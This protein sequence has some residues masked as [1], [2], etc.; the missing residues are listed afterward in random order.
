[1]EKDINELNDAWKHA[2]DS[3]VM[4]AATQ[5]FEEYPPHVQAII[6]TEAKERGLWEKVLYL[7][8]EKTSEPK[9]G[10][11]EGYV[12][13]GCKGTYLNFETG[14]C[15]RCELPS[16]DMGYCIKCNK[17]WPIQPGQLCPEHDVKLSRHKAAMALLR[18]GNDIFDI[19]ILRILAFPAFFLVGIALS[20]FVDPNSFG[21]IDPLTE[22][23]LGLSYVFLYYFIFESI[24]QRT[25]GK[26]IT[27]TRVI[28]GTGTKPSMG[29][30]AKRTLIRFV[31]FEAFSFLGENVYG[32]HDRWSGTYVVKAK[33][34]ASEKSKAD[35]LSITTSS[36]EKEIIV[37]KNKKVTEHVCVPINHDCTEN[38]PSLAIPQEEIVIQEQNNITQTGV[39]SDKITVSSEK[40]KPDTDLGTHAIILSRLEECANCDRIIGKLE[41]AYIFK[42]HIV[43]KQCY[44]RLKCQ[45]KS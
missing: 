11:L 44:N 42:N 2:I 9:E 4:K 1:M 6:E 14:R 40:V 24:C 10:N 43:C 41:Q 12:C 31:P 33:R 20:L 13:D 16:D 32:W 15:M 27:G 37:N 29:T 36:F 19:I 26:F 5:D 21:E 25:P 22:F 34:I 39:E 8:G 3:D 45:K 18:L 23:F 38:V 17:F 35:T 28:T 30:I 7:R